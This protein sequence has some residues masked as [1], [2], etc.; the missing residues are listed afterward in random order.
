MTNAS[1]TQGFALGYRPSP[2]QGDWRQAPPYEIK[3]GVA[4]T[5]V[6]ETLACR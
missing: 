3:R 2:L 6:S 4:P 5:V 1:R